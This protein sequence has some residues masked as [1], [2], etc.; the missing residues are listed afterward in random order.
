MKLKDALRWAEIT[1][2]TEGPHPTTKEAVR[3][4][5]DE[6]KRLQAELADV[7]DANEYLQEELVETRENSIYW[8]NEYNKATEISND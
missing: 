4:L 5:Y 1:L 7:L 6:V 8:E 2:K 3:T